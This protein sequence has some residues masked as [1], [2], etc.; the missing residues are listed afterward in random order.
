MLGVIWPRLATYVN[1]WFQATLEGQTPNQEKLKDTVV[2]EGGKIN[3]VMVRGSRG[4]TRKS[5]NSYK[6]IENKTDKP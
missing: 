5:A 1:Q 3:R 6:A 2:K 4:N